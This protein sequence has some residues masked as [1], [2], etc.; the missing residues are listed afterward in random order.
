M[1]RVG[2][3]AA[4]ARTGNAAPRLTAVAL[5][6]GVPIRAAAAVRLRR[7][8]A[9]PR[10]GIASTS[11]M[12]LVERRAHDR[13]AADARAGLARIGARA[14]VAVVACGAVCDRRVRA[15]A[16][17][18]RVGRAGVVVLARSAGTVREAVF[19]RH[20]CVEVH[21]DVS[22]KER[23]RRVGAVAGLVGA[24]EQRHRV[25]RID[26]EAVETGFVR[27]WDL[28]LPVRVVFVSWASSCSGAHAASTART[29]MTI[30]STR[31]LADAPPR[32]SRGAPLD[33]SPRVAWSCCMRE[34][35]PRFEEIEHH[36]SG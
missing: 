32:R 23:A 5:R 29:P 26:G 15:R 28:L 18:T 34:R 10:R 4:H 6:A 22:P 30:A 12:A 1:T 3:R 19:I 7:V 24:I 9:S 21:E 27:S 16:G 11:H 25:R 35:R 31:S 13:I 33:R 36:P 17:G 8:R 20:A 14:G 2:R